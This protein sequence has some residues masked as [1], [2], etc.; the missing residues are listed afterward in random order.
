M[1]RV[2]GGNLIN[3]RHN[4]RNAVGSG[5]KISVIPRPFLTRNSLRTVTVE[6]ALKDRILSSVVLDFFRVICVKL[7]VRIL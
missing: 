3:F 4:D 7:I 2:G 5:N 6:P 1:N